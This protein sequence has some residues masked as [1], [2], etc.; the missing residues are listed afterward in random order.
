MPAVPSN[1]CC[2][3]STAGYRLTHVLL[4][5]HHHD[6]VAEL[7]QVTARYPDVPVLI[8]PLERGLVEGAT[9][10][11]GPGEEIKVG[12]LNIAALHTPGHTAGMISLL[13]EAP[14]CSPATRCS[15]G[16]S[17]AYAPPAARTSPTSRH[18]IM[19]V[20]L[21][22]PPETGSTPVTPRRRPSPTSF[23]TTHSCASGAAS[24]PGD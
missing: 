10:D 21:A 8:H 24:T 22:L 15:R 18:S 12:S 2:R 11:L 17:A 13:I 1:R 3:R 23:H 7:D 20:L 14:T 19:D 16:P 9:G 6:H 5:H 4:T